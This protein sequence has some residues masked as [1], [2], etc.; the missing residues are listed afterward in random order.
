MPHSHL[1]C[2]ET[3]PIFSK[4]RPALPP[5]SSNVVAVCDELLFV[6]HNASLAVTHLESKTAAAP[7]LSVCSKRTA[8]LDTKLVLIFIQLIS[9]DLEFSIESLV[10]N[11]TGEYLAVQGARGQLVVVCIDQ[12]ALKRYLDVEETSVDC[13]TLRIG[14]SDHT[15][16][17]TKMMWHPLSRTQTCLMVLTRDG[18][19]R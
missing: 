9:P 19:L 13:R 18:L 12:I 15:P 16:P 10:P 8:L 1:D 4:A 17:I 6:A 2:I 3:L 5:G 7:F 11:S 14:K